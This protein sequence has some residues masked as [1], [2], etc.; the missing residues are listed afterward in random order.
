MRT[1][2]FVLALPLFSAEKPSDLDRQ[3]LMAH[4]EMTESWLVDEVS[5]LSPAQLA[6]RPAPGMFSV[7]EC[8]QHL[9]LSE[10]GYWKT[11]L[12]EIKNKPTK[13]DSPSEDIDRLWYG[14]DRTSHDK[15]PPPQ[16]PNLKSADL[17]PVLSEFL[18]LRKT[19]R[20]HVKTAQED[21]RHH[22]IP[23]WERDAYQWLLMISAH[24][25]RH[26]LQL[27]EVKH[28][29]DFPKN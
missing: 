28:H 22:M 10:P 26:I 24:S 20:E 6:F 11:Y 27:R 1:L 15:T 18:A 2:L 3:H 19:M 21:W 9:N 29:P 14:I 8:I 5:H 4:F 25:Q 7:L 23:G 13:E 16:V 17:A 12:R